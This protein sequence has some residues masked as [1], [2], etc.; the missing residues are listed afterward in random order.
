MQKTKKKKH[1]AYA[2]VPVDAGVN[3]REIANTMSEIGFTMNHSSARNYVLRIMNKFVTA[4]SK[5]YNIK[6][7]QSEISKIVKSPMF[8]SGICELLVDIE[9]ERR[10]K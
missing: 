1:S 10:E 9:S 8:Q 7:N 3:Y 5:E 6:L 4:I 2:T